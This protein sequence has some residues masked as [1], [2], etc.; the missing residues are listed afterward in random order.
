MTTADLTS[1]QELLE[2]DHVREDVTVGDDS[3]TVRVVTAALTADHLD[4]GQLVVVGT[5]LLHQPVELHRLHVQREELGVGDG[6]VAVLRLLQLLAQGRVGLE[7][8][9]V[10]V[11]HLVLDALDGDGRTRL[12]AAVLHLAVEMTTT[13]L[14]RG[15]G[16]TEDLVVHSDGVEGTA[17]LVGRD[18]RVEPVVQLLP[19][20]VRELG[21]LALLG[22]RAG[23]RPLLRLEPTEA[24]Q[25][26]CTVRAAL[27]ERITVP[28]HLESTQLL[29]TGRRGGLIREV[30]GEG[31]ELLHLLVDV[32]VTDAE[33]RIR[34]A[35]H[36]VGGADDT[37][38]GELGDHRADVPVLEE[39]P[40][41]GL[42]AVDRRGDQQGGEELQRHS[43]LAT[44]V[45]LGGEVDVRLQS[46]VAHRDRRLHDQSPEHHRVD[47]HSC[48]DLTRRRGLDAAEDVITGQQ[49][50]RVDVSHIVVQLVQDGVPIRERLV[51]EL[52]ETPVQLR[53]L[54]LDSIVT[55]RGGLVALVVLEDTVA[56]QLVGRPDDDEGLDSLDGAEEHLEEVIQ[57]MTTEALVVVHP[58]LIADDD[59]LGV[60]PHAGGPVH[61]LAL[62]AQELGGRVRD[63]LHVPR[64]GDRDLV[65][66]RTLVL[67]LLEDDTRLGF[68]DATQQRLTAAQVEAP[69]NPLGGVPPNG[70][71]TELLNVDALVVQGVDL[72]VEQISHVTQQFTVG[73]LVRLLGQ[74]VLGDLGHVLVREQSTKVDLGLGVSPDRVVVLLHLSGEESLTR[75]EGD[76]RLPGT[77]RHDDVVVSTELLDDV[78][79][80]T[81]H[82]VALE[83][84]A[85]LD[86]P[87]V[88]HDGAVEPGAHGVDAE[89][90]VVTLH[91]LM[92]VHQ[93][94]IVLAPGDDARAVE[95]L[96]GVSTEVLGGVGVHRHLVDAQV[97]GPARQ[98]T[99]GH[100]GSDA[101]ADLG[102][103]VDSRT[104]TGEQLAPAGGAG[105]EHHVDLV[106]AD[107][108]PH[109]AVQQRLDEGEVLPL[110]RHRHGPH[111]PGHLLTVGLGDHVVEPLERVATDVGQALIEVALEELTAPEALELLHS[112]AGDCKDLVHED[113]SFGLGC[114]P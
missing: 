8:A 60:P 87:Q 63:H 18:Q 108:R 82:E 35:V 53:E 17:E 52:R 83:Q 102:H 11:A 36:Q 92:P 90:R 105:D 96:L 68:R 59:H 40:V 13:E 101:L 31:E 46:A 110:L 10:H 47:Q 34:T 45:I 50:T 86:V 51:D 20:G 48:A 49:L 97:G 43:R 66:R 22:A 3:R 15:Q 25:D 21:V 9:T 70:E 112:T 32:A 114:L 62:V 24:T 65:P 77:L 23:N 55:P 2:L 107:I 12:V 67:C 58:V 26:A 33:E 57:V 44:Q 88:D 80:V 29:Q 71:V 28:S 106:G 98:R 74:E 91:A 94:E 5:Q 72:V 19:L 56:T 4:T 95:E 16:Q 61:D 103:V 42:A 73:D 89:L 54:L 99:T 81:H 84:A 100:Q 1:H 6:L 109:R 27:A 104:E 37:L 30:T 41:D 14:V 39:L 85:L 78:F 76:A 38:L 64:A 75:G 113:P 7:L 93:H 79:D 111:I 69:G